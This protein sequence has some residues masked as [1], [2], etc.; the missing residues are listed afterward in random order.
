M[1]NLTIFVLMGI[2]YV[3]IEVF[4]SAIVD[5]KLRLVGQ[6]SIWMF[7]VGGLMGVVI[8]QYNRYKVTHLPYPRNIILGC[9]LITFMEFVSGL[10]LNKICGFAIWDY[11]KNPLNLMGQIDIIHS[12]CWLLITPVIMWLDDVIRFYMYEEARPA[13]F[14]RYFTSTK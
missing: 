11:S 1:K 12:T 3:C 9:L 4:F 7:L 6:S 5:M 13:G 10:I 14:W 8:G 2:L